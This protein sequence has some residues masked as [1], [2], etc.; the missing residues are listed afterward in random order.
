MDKIETLRLM[1]PLRALGL[2]ALSWLGEHVRERSFAPGEQL[3]EQGK[4]DRDCYFLVS[5]EVDVVRD[6]KPVARCGAGDPEGELAL[7]YR[8]PRSATVT[9]VGPVEALV[10]P[11]GDFDAAEKT[12]PEVTGPISQALRAF[13][14]TRFSHPSAEGAR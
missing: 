2:P 9:A 13:L 14:A 3:I 4:D 7:L 5:G 12:S 11:A 10:L 1:P 8:G 6:G